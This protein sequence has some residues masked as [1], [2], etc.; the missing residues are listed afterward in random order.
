MGQNRGTEEGVRGTEQ[1]RRRESEDRTEGRRRESEGQNRD[2]GGSR[3]HAGCE[4]SQWAQRLADDVQALVWWLLVHWRHWVFSEWK[5]AAEWPYPAQLRQRRGGSTHRR[6]LMWSK[7]IFRFFRRLRPRSRIFSP[8][9][10]VPSRG[11]SFLMAMTPWLSM[12]SADVK[13]RWGVGV[14]LSGVGLVVDGGGGRFAH[15]P[16]LFLAEECLGLGTV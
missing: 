5:C 3:T 1:G 9:F 6:R 11:R 8:V 7:P 15:E 13:Q 10:L 16:L 12:L 4:P 2:G 14:R